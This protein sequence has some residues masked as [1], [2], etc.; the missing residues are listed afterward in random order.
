MKDELFTCESERQLP[1]KHLSSVFL[2][3]PALQQVDHEREVLIETDCSDYI[4]AG[5][6]S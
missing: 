3:P 5:V 4:S 1:F 2:T 6:L